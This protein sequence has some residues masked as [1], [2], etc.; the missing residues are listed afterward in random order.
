MLI[1]WMGLINQRT[2]LWGHHP[3]ATAMSKHPKAPLSGFFLLG[4]W[5]LPSRMATNIYQ[6]FLVG[7]IPM[8]VKWDD[9]Y[10]QLKGKTCSKPPTRFQSQWSGV[11]HARLFWLQTPVFDAV[12]WTGIASSLKSN[13][14]CRTIDMAVIVMLINIPSGKLT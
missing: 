4:V 5:Y 1:I 2:W 14:T 10:S 9:D 13:R 3:V 12:L 11:K 8:K 7:G 6:S